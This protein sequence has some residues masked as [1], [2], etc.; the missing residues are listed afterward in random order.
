MVRKTHRKL[1]SSPPVQSTTRSLQ[2]PRNR[3]K[4]EVPS[5][6]FTLVP[7]T[8]SHILQP[9]ARLF[10]CIATC[11]TTLPFLTHSIRT[12]YSH[13]SHQ[14]PLSTRGNLPQK[15]TS[16]EPHIFIPCEVAKGISPSPG[17]W[18]AFLS[19]IHSPC[20]EVKP[21]SG[22]SGEASSFPYLY[23]AQPC[24]SCLLTHEAADSIRTSSS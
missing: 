16:K 15:L 23:I 10:S 2:P 4:K 8:Q 13:H 11:T 22:A 7:L 3:P 18:R 21:I 19:H 14:S 5:S 20:R 17:P 12:P 9:H 24:A 1:T 6:F